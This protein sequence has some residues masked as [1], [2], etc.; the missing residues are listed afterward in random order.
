MRGTR[1]AEHVRHAL[2]PHPTHGVYGPVSDRKILA[3]KTIKRLQD[4]TCKKYKIKRLQTS[5]K[6]DFKRG[7]RFATWC[8]FKNEGLKKKYGPDGSDYYQLARI[9][10]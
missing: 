10:K 5:V 3:A 4:E 1:T 2:A 8:G 6:A 7:I 9:F